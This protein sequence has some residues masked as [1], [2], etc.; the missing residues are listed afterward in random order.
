MAADTKSSA[1]VDRMIDVGVS[2]LVPEG[3]AQ[4]G[5]GPFSLGAF[6]GDLTMPY[7]TP[8][9]MGRQCTERDES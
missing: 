1:V 5:S 9:C 8:R 3:W 4:A 7:D 6:P 2:G